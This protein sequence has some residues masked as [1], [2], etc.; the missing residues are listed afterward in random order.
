[1]V[2][3]IF[4][5]LTVR[6]VGEIL[7]GDTVGEMLDGNQVDGIEVGLPDTAVVGNTDNGDLED[8]TD[9][10]N[11]EGTLVS[12]DLVG[13]E[14]GVHVVGKLLEGVTEV[15]SIDLVGEKDGNDVGGRVGNREGDVEVG[16]NKLVGEVDGTAVAGLMLGNRVGC[17]V[18]GGLGTLVGEEVEDMMGGKDRND[19]GETVGNREGDV[20]VGSNELV[21][22]VDGTAVAGLMLGNREGCFVLGGLGTLVGEENEDMVGEND[23][24]DEPSNANF[25][26]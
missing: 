4:V 10:G 2:V 17:F 3:F 20:E 6:V 19:V 21:G 5:G 11:V 8:S 7:E 9:E 24:D 13:E 15:G 22:E 25:A 12:G 1:M 23:G 18:L 26:V 14:R 16:S